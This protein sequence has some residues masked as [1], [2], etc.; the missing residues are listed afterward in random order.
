MRI[1]ARLDPEAQEQIKYLTE[2]TGQGVSL[3]VREAVAHYYVHVRQRAQRKA[4]MRLLAMVGKYDSGH[5]EG[6]TNYKAIVG[7]AIDAKFATSHPLPK[8]KR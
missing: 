8:R 7:Q 1:N 2:A 5:S 4:P 3:V 6:A